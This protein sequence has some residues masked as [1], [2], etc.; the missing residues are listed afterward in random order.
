MSYIDQADHSHVGSFLDIALY[1]PLTTITG[2]EFHAD[3]TNL[4]IGGGSGE[5]PGMVVKNLDYC[6]MTYLELIAQACKI[7]SE[8]SDFFQNWDDSLSEEQWQTYNSHK[9]LDYDWDM[10]TLGAFISRVD[11]HFAQRIEYFHNKDL[12][13]SD[14]VEEKICI[15]MGEFVYFS[16]Q[17]LLSDNLQAHLKTQPE[18]LHV[19]PCFDAVN[20]PPQGYPV[21]GRKLVTENGQQKVQWGL[22]F[23]EESKEHNQEDK[24][25]QVRRLLVETITENLPINAGLL[26]IDEKGNLKSESKDAWRYEGVKWETL[27]LTTLMDFVENLQFRMKY[28]NTK[29]KP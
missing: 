5:H 6:V 21:S 8:K 11:S 3:K 13:I 17:H 16:A 24:L 22:R 19:M 2:D 15:M 29:T 10:K 1:H 7:D 25:A 27:P 14:R 9:A 18:N 28:Q 23:D 4:V 20:V 12:D 26:S